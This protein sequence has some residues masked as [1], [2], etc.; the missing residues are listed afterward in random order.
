[1]RTV[2]AVAMQ[3]LSKSVYAVQQAK[4]AI[5]EGCAV[6]IEDGLKIE[7]AAWVNCFSE[8]GEGHEGMTA[9]VEKRKPKF[10]DF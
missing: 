4:K 1:M 3:I 7:N 9:F 2:Q 8:E 6:S 5:N 10:R